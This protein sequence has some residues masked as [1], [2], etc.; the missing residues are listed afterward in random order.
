MINKKPVSFF[1]IVAMLFSLSVV[2]AESIMRYNT[3]W[4]DRLENDNVTVSLS[5]LKTAD[6]S[7]GLEYTSPIGQYYDHAIMDGYYTAQGMVRLTANNYVSIKPD[8]GWIPTEDEN[9]TSYLRMEFT[10]GEWHSIK[11]VFA[12]AKQTMDW[13][14]DDKYVGRSRTKMN[15]PLNAVSVF[16]ASADK[17]GLQVKDVGVF[18]ADNELFFEKTESGLV[19]AEKNSSDGKFYG[20]DNVSYINDSVINVNN[21]TKMIKRKEIGDVGRYRVRGSI[22]P[23]ASGGSIELYIYK[24]GEK[25]WEQLFPEGETG[26]YDVRIF[27]DLGSTIDV[28]VTAGKAGGYQSADWSCSFERFVGTLYCD[29][30]TGRGYSYKVKESTLLKDYVLKSDTYCYSVKYDVEYPMVKNSINDAYNSGILDT[31][32]GYISAHGLAAPGKRVDNVMRIKVPKT[33]IIKITGDLVLSENSDGVVTDIY[34]NDKKIWSSRV[35]GERSVRWDEPFDTTYFSFNVNCTVYAEEGDTLSF[36]FNQWRKLNNDVVN[37]ND[38]KIDY[39]EGEVCSETT[40]WKL[41]KSVYIDVGNKKLIKDGE[42]YSSE[43]ISNDGAVLIAVDE[44]EDIYGSNAAVPADLTLVSNKEYCEIEA[45]A[46]LNGRN[47]VFTDNNDA[48]IY[49]DIPVKFSWTELSEI[50]TKNTADE[51]GLTVSAGF[52]NRLGN[53]VNKFAEDVKYYVSLNAEN[54]SDEQ[55]SFYLVLAEYNE[56]GSLRQ[57]V[58]AKNISVPEYGSLT[59]N[60]SSGADAISFTPYYKSSQLKLFVFRGDASLRPLANAAKLVKGF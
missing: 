32:G 16:G 24:D 1:I 26:I 6:A 28:A 53:A 43:V 60:H 38:I 44:L 33:G 14:L 40:K 9:N 21:Q 13:Y 5:F 25:V 54:I 22:T 39:I 35:G 37:F 50:N 59:I 12:K 58:C 56:D 49:E 51:I 36:S 3:L 20:T 10:K 48:I 46:E 31:D 2:Y 27:G 18:G 15:V 45:S 57:I 8:G 55:K 41:E 11:V 30:D 17:A 52:V 29:A 4:F 7:Y 47:I 34:H 42:E 23:K 19:A